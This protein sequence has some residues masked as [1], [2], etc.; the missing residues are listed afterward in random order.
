M[1]RLTK[2]AIWLY[3][4]LLFFEGALRKWAFPGWSQPLLIVRDPVLLLIY[5][6]ALMSGIVPRSRFMIF[7]GALAVASLCGSYL[8]GQN[9]LWVTLFGLRSNY[10]H[11]P[12]IWVMAEA[13][14]R[15][16]VEQ[17]GAFILIVVIP[18]TVLMVMQF[19]SPIGSWINRGVGEDDLGQIYGASGH[20]RPPGFFTFITG[21]MVFF[22]LAAAFFLYQV[23]MVK[24]SFWWWLLVLWPCGAGIVLAIPISI[25]R[26]TMIAT[27]LVIAVF[28]MCLVFGGV[29]HRLKR[30]PLKIFGRLSLAGILIGG[31]LAFTPLFQDA[32]EVFMDRWDTAA[33]E[34]EGDAVG[35]LISRI[36]TAFSQPIDTIER[37]PPFGYGIGVG[38]NVGARLL[39][40]RTG[41][42]LAEDEW[43]R[44]IMELGPSLGVAFIVFRISLTIFLGYIALRALRQDNDL[45]PM[46]IFSAAAWI[47]MMNQ[48]GQA[49]QLGF[50]VV[51]GGLLLASVNHNDEEEDE[52]DETDEDADEEDD[53]LDED[54]SED[55]EESAEEEADVPSPEISEF[56]ARRRRM[57]GL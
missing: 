52:N 4:S 29:T 28:L 30:L 3:I 53:E 43:G 8:A 9:N 45:L 24:H 51:G 38:T 17:I 15:K 32:R 46:L 35:S 7:L 10:L 19:K 1:I 6:L 34:A 55:S 37:T 26:G 33:A 11:V 27:F 23:S 25:S 47:I 40:G 54:D 21:P 16:D 44:V 56:E 39:A 57:R 20:I 13:F 50:A 2:W 5:A 41:F 49:T 18:M 42:L 22:P 48:W 31:C 14:K 12:L 36:T